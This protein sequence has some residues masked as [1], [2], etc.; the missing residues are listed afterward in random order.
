VATPRRPAALHGR[1]FRRS[2][3]LADGVLTPSEL[4]SSAWRRLYRGVY[5]DARLPD[6]F[7]IRVRGAGLLM[8]SAAAFGGRTAAFLHGAGELVE[9]GS[10]VEVHLPVGERFGPHAG[11]RVRQVSLPEDDVMT[12]GQWRCTTPLRTALDIAR[13]EPLV[14]AVVALDRLMAAG[15]VGARRLAEAVAGLPSGRGS[16]KARRAVELADRR[17]ESQ[18]ES[19]LRVVLALAGLSPVPQYTVRDVDG[20]FVA[21][22]DLAF[23]EQRI[24]IEYDGAWHGAVGQLRKDRR[25]LNLLA[26]AGWTVLH[27][28]AADMY[29]P[30][31]VVVQVR[32]LL[33]GR[34]F[35]ESA[36]SGDARGAASPKLRGVPRARP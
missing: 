28:T 5:A 27:V 6:G 29:A 24:A 32:A 35:G 1:V 34:N 16:R 7:G 2:D 12:V 33:R 14:D 17:A 3:V 20:N 4:R 30:H 13:T 22:V 26:A 21:R 25:R 11:L 23:P 31:E 18:P 15:V 10:P 19:R 9:R 8:P 36:R